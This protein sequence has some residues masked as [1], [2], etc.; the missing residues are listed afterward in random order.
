ME[1][2][3]ADDN[4]TSA[5]DVAAILKRICEGT[6]VNGDASQKMLTILKGQTVRGKIPAGLPE[7]FQSANKTGEMPEG[8]G[9]GCIEN[10]SA[11]VFPP[12][13]MGEGYILTVMSNDLGGRNAEAISTTAQVSSMVAQWYTEQ[14]EEQDTELSTEPDEGQ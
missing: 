1:S 12:E 11:I 3:P 10:D 6:L 7:G 13:G 8:Y 14:E 9:L 2:S 4:Y 5:L